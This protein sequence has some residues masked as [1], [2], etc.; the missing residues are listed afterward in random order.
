MTDQNFTTDDAG[1][2][3]TSDEHS[4]TI[5]TDGPILLQ[6]H[7]LIE[8]M[9]QFNRERVAE[10]QPHAKG[11][12]AFGRFEVTEDVSAYTK[13]DLFQPGKKT[14]LLIRFSSV[15]GERGSPDTWRDP[16]GFAVKFYTEQGNY[17]MVGNNTPVFFVRDPMKFQDFIR[18]QKRRADNNLRDHDM[19]WDFWTLS[20]ESAHQVTWLMGDR[21]IPRT[22]RHMNG[23]SSH[24]YMWVNAAGEKFWVKYH[25]HTDQGIEF[26]TQHEGDQM[27]SVDTDYHTRDLWEHIDGGEY[28]SWTLKMQIMPFEDADDYRFNPFDLTK[29]WP[30]GDYPLIPVGRMTLDRNPTDYHCEI[31]QAAF[32]PSNLV[33]GIGPSPDKMLIGRLFSYPD[34]HRYRIG[35]NYKE[36]PVNRPHVPVHSYSKDGNMRHRNPGDP[37]YVPNSKGGPHADPSQVGETATWYGA[38]DMVRSP[39]VLHKEDDDWGQ[40]GT[41]VRDVLDDAARD[42]LV[43]NVVGHLL[44]GVSEPILA[45]AFEYWRNVDKTLGDRI[46][47]GVSKKQSETDPKAGEQANPARS[48]AQAKA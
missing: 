46:A 44:N 36:L 16:R 11:G 19:Q 41:M 32:E 33:P 40:A 38:G 31:E 2:P 17:D 45:K 35:A 3:V 25:F 28:P 18:S 22:W 37:V 9:A 8:K 27:A 26:F 47:D 29:V 48:S 39:Y 34:A 24:T 4:L 21:G 20:P 6:D 1:I 23:Y 5:G 42:R 30:H 10:R 13:A 14:D 12:G 7:Y 15:A 43:D